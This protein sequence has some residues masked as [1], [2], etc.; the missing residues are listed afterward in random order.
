MTNGFEARGTPTIKVAEDGASQK[1]GV[2]DAGP[3]PTSH[4]E[5]GLLENGLAEVGTCQV[6]PF[7]FRFAKVRIGENSFLEIRTR[8][9]CTIEVGLAQVRANQECTPEGCPL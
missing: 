4:C 6:C 7:E 5:V 8:K 1:I 2:G 3:T 9:V